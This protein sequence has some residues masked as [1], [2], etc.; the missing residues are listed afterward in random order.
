MTPTHRRQRAWLPW[1]VRMMVV[2]LLVPQFTPL[3]TQA[4]NGDG[5][6]I[7]LPSMVGGT[8]AAADV[9]GE[10]SGPAEQEEAPAGDLPAF[11]GEVVE[12]APDDEVGAAETT[13][14]TRL[15]YS[16]GGTNLTTRWCRT[17][18]MPSFLLDADGGRIRMIMQHETDSRDQLRVVELFVGHEYTS[19]AYGNRGRYPGRYGW[20]RQSGGGEYAWILGDNTAH[21]LAN[22]WNWATITDYFPGRSGVLGGNYIALCS[23]PHVTTRFI[24]FDQ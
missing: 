9:T 13:A 20:A 5:H 19:N 22:P 16:V 12:M 18:L 8:G 24:F 2:A 3:A 15:F 7:Y 4:Q 14:T 6:A 10:G 21:T 23:H 11:D 17:V 1:M